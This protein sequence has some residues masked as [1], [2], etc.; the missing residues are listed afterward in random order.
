[1]AFVS[2]LM[3]APAIMMLTVALLSSVCVVGCSSPEDGGAGGGDA[4]TTASDA[5]EG[6]SGEASGSDDSSGTE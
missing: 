4:D 3:K 5:G 1:M 2:K 6:G